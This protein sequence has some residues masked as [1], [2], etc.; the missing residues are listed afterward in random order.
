MLVLKNSSK[1]SH[2][3]ANRTAGWRLEA[4]LTNKQINYCTWVC[5]II[6]YFCFFWLSDC[7]RDC[8]FL[9]LNCMCVC[10]HFTGNV[11]NKHLSIGI[12]NCFIYTQNISPKH[13]KRPVV[14][15]YKFKHTHTHSS[16]SI[17]IIYCYKDITRQEATR[18]I[19]EL[20]LRAMI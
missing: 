5:P 14:L 8:L 15:F 18:V 20:F 6:N 19:K 7:C 3:L 9:H 13:H 2:L 4:P 12:E 17:I 1:S 10:V 11:N 16:L